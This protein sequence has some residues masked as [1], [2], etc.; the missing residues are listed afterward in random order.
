[1]SI[2]A[3]KDEIVKDLMVGVDGPYGSQ[4]WNYSQIGIGP[5][6]IQIWKLKCYGLLT[7]TKETGKALSIHT[8]AWKRYCH[9]ILDIV[10]EEGAI[11][12]ANDFMSL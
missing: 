1:M 12:R 7:G 5:N 3:I 8:P 2:D 6:M 9:E 4:K 10:E 11:L